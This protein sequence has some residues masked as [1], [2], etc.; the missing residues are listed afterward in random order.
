MAIGGNEQAARLS[1]I[2][3]DAY[4]FV[5]Y[6]VLGTVTAFAG[7]ILTG[8]LG[9][10]QATMAGGFEFEVIAAVVI[11]GTSLFG[12]EANL[13]GSVGGAVLVAVLRNGL[14]LRGLDTNWI[15]I[16]VGGVMVVAVALD[17]LRRSRVEPLGRRTRTIGD[18]DD[19]ESVNSAPYLGV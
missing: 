14:L 16:V 5:H 12:G 8:R 15:N 17:G 10:A 3:V 9:A 1:G 7:L 4:K 6:T 11:G 18:P 13:A 2:K 19:L